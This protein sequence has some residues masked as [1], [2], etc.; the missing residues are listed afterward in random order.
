MLAI[1]DT[2]PILY[3]KVLRHLNRRPT[4]FPFPDCFEFVVKRLSVVLPEGDEPHAI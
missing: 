3:L 2:G 4:T 1:N